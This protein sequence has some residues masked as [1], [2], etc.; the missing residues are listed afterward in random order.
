MQV[1]AASTHLEQL[2]HSPAHVRTASGRP[3][4]SAPISRT[5]SHGQNGRPHKSAPIRRTNS[6]LRMHLERAG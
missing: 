4:N 3:H 5:C 2:S 6:Y 1:I